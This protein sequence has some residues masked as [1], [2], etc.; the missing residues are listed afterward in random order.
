MSVANLR[1]SGKRKSVS[2]KHNILSINFLLQE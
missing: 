2:C 1:G